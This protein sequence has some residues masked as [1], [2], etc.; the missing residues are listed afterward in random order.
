[1]VDSSVFHNA[2]NSRFPPS[3]GTAIR[4][5]LQ[6]HQENSNVPDNHNND[7]NNTVGAIQTASVQDQFA[8]LSRDRDQFRSESE[9]ARTEL[10]RLQEE[11]QGLQQQLAEL[12]TKNYQAQAELGDHT[13][14]VRLLE[15]ERARILRLTENESRALQDCTNH[16]IN[17]EQ[18]EAAAK[19]AFIDEMQAI[20][21]EMASL[22][23]RRMIRKTEEYISAR[24]VSDV[25][26]KIEKQNG[27][28]L[29]NYRTQ[30]A[31]L[32]EV[33]KARDEKLSRVFR[34]RQ[35]LQQHRRNGAPEAFE[36]ELDGSDYPSKAQGT[37]EIS[38]GTR[39]S[40]HM[41]LFYGPHDA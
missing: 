19:K 11:H 24:S 1:M 36:M 23:Q 12:V 37:T 3:T 38:E 39:G 7:S 41:K 22:L 8:S 31:E 35:A 33:T 18:R 9:Q 17:M 16:T 32:V 28:T 27:Y 10:T 14:K 34:L 13:N 6:H 29:V 40:E 20:N 25:V 15:Q 30:H 4:Q 5:H 26:A 21:D 2:M